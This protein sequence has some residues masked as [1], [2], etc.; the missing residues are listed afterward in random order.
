[1]MY[2]DSMHLEQHAARNVARRTPELRNKITVTRSSGV[3]A[4]AH[5]CTAAAALRAMRTS[6]RNNSPGN[7]LLKRSN[8]KAVCTRQQFRLAM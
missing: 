6:S 3:L 4:I 8:C 1:M 5:A 2:A 7:Y